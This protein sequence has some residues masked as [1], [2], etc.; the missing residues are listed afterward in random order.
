MEGRLVS[1][2]MKEKRGSLGTRRKEVE[3]EEERNEKENKT[4]LVI[5]VSNG[6]SYPPQFA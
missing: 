5:S 2:R 3:H 4:Y 6:V 1:R